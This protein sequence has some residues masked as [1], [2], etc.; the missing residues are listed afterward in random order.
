MPGALPVNGF[1]RV[2]LRAYG[3]QVSLPYPD[4]LLA[5]PL[6]RRLLTGYLGFGFGGALFG[7]LGLG[8]VPGTSALRPRGAPRRRQRPAR[9]WQDVAPAEARAVISAAVQRGEWREKR[10]IR[11]P[12]PRQEP[13]AVIPLAGICAGAARKG[14]PYRD[15]TDLWKPGGEIPP[16]YPTPGEI[17]RTPPARYGSACKIAL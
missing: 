12:H 15:R 14:G 7:D 3:E 5:S 1:W 11:R 10:A 6:G 9:A 13:S 2:A 4:L 16:G 8:E 17:P